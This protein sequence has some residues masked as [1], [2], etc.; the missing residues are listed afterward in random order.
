M[1]LGEKKLTASG[2]KST[3]ATRLAAMANELEYANP[4]IKMMLLKALA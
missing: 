3:V 1:R 4:L 2:R